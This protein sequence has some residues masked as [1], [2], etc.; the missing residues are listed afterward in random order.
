[1]GIDTIV[2]GDFHKSPTST[3]LCDMTLY[4]V[5][6]RSIDVVEFFHSHKSTT[7]SVL[8]DSVHLFGSRAESSML[9]DFLKSIWDM[10][11]LTDISFTEVRFFNVRNLTANNDLERRFSNCIIEFEVPNK[12]AKLR[13]PSP[14]SLKD[15][16][17]NMFL[18]QPENVA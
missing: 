13:A 4:R 6:V 12:E 2:Y 7:G 17:T 8:L 15:Y 18:T 3:D 9:H 10:G 5:D 1:M 16:L 11:F 14:T